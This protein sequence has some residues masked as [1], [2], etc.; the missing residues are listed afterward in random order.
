[1]LSFGKRRSG[2]PR[3][4]GSRSKKQ[5]KS[6]RSGSRKMYK[7]IIPAAALATLGGIGLMKYQDRQREM[8][9]WN[10]LLNAK[11]QQA[12]A[13]LEREQK[14]LEQDL[15]ELGFRKG[16]HWIRDGQSFSIGLQRSDINPDD[17]TEEKIVN[18]RRYYLIKNPDYV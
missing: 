10:K 4:S 13:E 18:G 1:M 16:H 14:I 2:R 11:R 9:E 15:V 7:W 3:R 17:I 8:V 12:I 5:R 6:R